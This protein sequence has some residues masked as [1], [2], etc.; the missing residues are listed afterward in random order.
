MDDEITVDANGCVEDTENNYA[1]VCSE[2]YEKL[3]T[4]RIEIEGDLIPYDIFNVGGKL[5]QKV[6]QT[7]A[8]AGQLRTL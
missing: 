8:R 1:L 5:V 2:N 6:Y 7:W 4:G 3:Q